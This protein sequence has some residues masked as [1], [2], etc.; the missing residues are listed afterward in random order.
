MQGGISIVSTDNINNSQVPLIS[1]ITVVYNGG[2]HL[3]RTIRSVIKQVYKNF[4]YIVID[5]GSID[6]TIDIL[7]KYEHSINKYISEP[8]NGLYDA[9]NKGLV[10]ASGDYVIFLNSDD[11][12]EDR[13]LIEVSNAIMSNPGYDIYHGYFLLHDK[14]RKKKRGSGILPTSFPA[15]QTS[16]FVRRT[17][18]GKMK[19]FD[20]KYKIAA[21]FKF[22][23]SLQLDGYKFLK[24]DAIVSNFSMGGA[25]S[26]TRTRLKEIEQ[27][28]IDLK[29]SKIIIAILMFRLRVVTNTFYI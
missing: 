16:C 22:L 13:A 4:E 27:I 10:L 5:G 29:Y 15:Y 25:S 24:L 21:D 8:D 20:D 23:K 1:I 11:W 19:W 2:K 7:K 17:I 26:D 12:L 14:T 9:M 6:E 28:L 18:F 3:E